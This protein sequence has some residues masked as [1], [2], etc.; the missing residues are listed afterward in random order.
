MT[1]GNPKDV[2]SSLDASQQGALFMQVT[3]MRDAT[4][5]LLGLTPEDAVAV[6]AYI[7]HEVAAMV[8]PEGA[9]LPA[10][11]EAA[12]EAASFAVDNLEGSAYARPAEG[13]NP[14]ARTDEH[15]EMCAS[16][17]SDAAAWT[18][19]F[20]DNLLLFSINPPFGVLITV[21]FLLHYVSRGPE[22]RE[23]DRMG[24]NKLG[25]PPVQSSPE[26]R[27]IAG[28]L[29]SNYLNAM[30]SLTADLAPPAT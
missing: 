11:V 16:E 17:A 24:D 12:R 15:G 18:E 6:A 10:T 23:A 7:L 27:V 2:L 19:G 3:A 9:E 30:A 13:K 29:L 22:L 28:A 1:Q 25:I 8:T 14:L 21:E 4:I 20:V 26:L 5:L